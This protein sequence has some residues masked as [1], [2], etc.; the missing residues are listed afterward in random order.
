L[1]NILHDY[2]GVFSEPLVFDEA[3]FESRFR[4]T[5]AVFMRI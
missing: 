2:W 4:M 3:D 5:R 1:P